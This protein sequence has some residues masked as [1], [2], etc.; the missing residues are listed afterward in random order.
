[1]LQTSMSNNACLAYIVELDETESE[2]EFINK[3]DKFYDKGIFLTCKDFLIDFDKI[4][5]DI[6][7]R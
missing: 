3:L 5:L 4:R 7:N 6:N 2:A 1:M